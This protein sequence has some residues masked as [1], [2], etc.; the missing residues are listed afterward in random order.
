MANESAA[1]LQA[2]ESCKELINKLDMLSQ[3]NIISI[4]QLEIETKHL[5]DNIDMLMKHIV[6]GNG[7]ESILTR[8]AKAEGKLGDIDKTIDVLEDWKNK[9]KGEIEVE[10]SKGKWQLIGTLLALALAIFAAS[11]GVIIGN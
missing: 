10:D 7:Q 8:I 9:H 2:L 6:H 1:I 5:N 4:A 11:K 3:N